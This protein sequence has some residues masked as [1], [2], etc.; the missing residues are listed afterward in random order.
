ME[1]LCFGLALMIAGVVIYAV[2]KYRC[3]Y[4]AYE[5]WAMVAFLVFFFGGG[6]VLVG[7]E[8]M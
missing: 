3:S 5:N 4:Y 6:L 8:G 7:L 2:A 1:A